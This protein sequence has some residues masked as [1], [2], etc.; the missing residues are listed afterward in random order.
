MP[1]KSTTALERQ[2]SMKRPAGLKNDDVNDDDDDAEKNE[3]NPE[4]WQFSQWT[5]ALG[6]AVFHFFH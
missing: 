2:E 1:E 5:A 4:L 3:T 6:Y